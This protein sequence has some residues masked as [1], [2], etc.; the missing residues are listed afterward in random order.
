[1]LYG[2]Y[3]Y[4]AIGRR[5]GYPIKLVKTREHIF[6]RWDDPNGER[7][8]IEASGPGFY[9]HPDNYYRVWP[10][11]VSEEWIQ[12]GGLLRSLSTREE[13]SVLLGNRGLCFL[14][15]LCVEDAVRALHYSCQADPNEEFHLNRWKIATLIHRAELAASNHGVFH[16]DPNEWNI[17]TPCKDWERQIYPSARQTLSRI[18]SNRRSTKTGDIRDSVCQTIV[19]SS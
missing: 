2:P 3:Y 12:M 4:A 11:P 10:K 19:Q 1:M 7:F 5:L 18:L 16:S 8:N 15:N 14:E 6:C 9:S 13:L 17:A